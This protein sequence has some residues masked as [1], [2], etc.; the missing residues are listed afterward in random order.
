LH[1]CDG[2]SRHAVDF[3]AAW[4]APDPHRARVAVWLDAKWR[5]TRFTWREQVESRLIDPDDDPPFFCRL[6]L[7]R[8]PALFVSLAHG[9]LVALQRGPPYRDILFRQPML[10]GPLTVNP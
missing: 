3:P 9:I 4:R 1:G 10:C 6:F 8:R 2:L 7:E 5:P